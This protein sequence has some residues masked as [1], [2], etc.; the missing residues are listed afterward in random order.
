MFPASMRLSALISI[1]HGP[2]HNPRST[3]EAAS[4][5]KD[6]AINPRNG[7]DRPMRSTSAIC[8]SGED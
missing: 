8:D 4:D 7:R 3:S 6:S 5:T 2:P 1:S